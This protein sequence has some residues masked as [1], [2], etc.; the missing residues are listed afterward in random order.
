MSAVSDLLPDVGDLGWGTQLNLWAAAVEAAAAG[1]GGGGT[2][3]AIAPD[4]GVRAV[5]KG[6]LM[7]NLLD[8]V[9]P[10]GSSDN[11]TVVQTAVNTAALTGRT[12]LIPRTAAPF[13]FGNITLPSGTDVLFSGATVTVPVGKTSMFTM[14]GTLGTPRSLTVAATSGARTLTVASG[15]GFAVGDLVRVLSQRNS[16]HPDSGPDW[17]LGYSTGTPAYFGEF[18]KVT[19]I[20]STSVTFAAGLL[21]PSYKPNSSGET[22]TQV[23]AWTTLEAVT[24]IK[25]V[26]IRGE[27][28]V[29]SAG[30]TASLS[31][32][33]CDLTEDV[34]VDGLTFD[35][36]GDG[37]FV[38]FQRSYRC[39]GRQVS[40][41]YSGSGAAGDTARTAY[42]NVSSQ[43][44]GFVECAADS[45]SQSFDA[46]YNTV[47]QMVCVNPYFIGC[48]T[49]GA[50]KNGLTTH[51]GTYAAQILNNRLLDC[52]DDGISCRT[53]QSII[54]GNRVSGP[55][56]VG[57][58]GINL[59]EGW[60]RNCI[61]SGNTVNA[62]EHGII[63]QDGSGA[64]E[65]FE[66]VGAK[67]V[68][69]TISNFSFAIFI[70]RATNTFAG[71]TGISIKGNTGVGCWDTAGKGVNVDDWV[72]GAKIEDNTFDLSG[73]GNAGVR[74]RANC[75]ANRVANNTIVNS[76]QYGLWLDNPTTGTATVDLGNGNHIV[77]AGTATHFKGANVIVGVPAGSLPA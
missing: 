32:I 18:H 11:S 41:R 75:T 30:L 73:V 54:S 3:T 20:T 62:F 43:D 28:T 72:S 8:Y 16:L 40:G 6:E 36:T 50:T 21:F 29:K 61:V 4:A 37:A 26:R 9:T 23:R 56:A 10:N 46:T 12:L 52:L 48:S 74:L 42:R 14:T 34:R 67:I 35:V 57:S 47:G 45:G 65:K 13:V 60:A 68:D 39:E 63:V 59:Y 66:W 69:N 24:P 44:C 25:G 49:R 22:D 70:D 7:V 77:N 58:Y 27:G 17:Q 1:G 76:S 51:A 55:N 2:V 19:A 71:I 5:G 38:W 64:G 15:H 53:R 31:L 33:M